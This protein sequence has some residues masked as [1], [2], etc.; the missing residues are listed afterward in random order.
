MK[1]IHHR[2]KEISSPERAVVVLDFTRFPVTITVTPFD[3]FPKMMIDQAM[4][5]GSGKTVV[6]S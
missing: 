1:E 4:E 2:W 3:V 5:D 6:I